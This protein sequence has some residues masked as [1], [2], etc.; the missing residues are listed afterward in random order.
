[1]QIDDIHYKG[2]SSCF[3]D[4]SPPSINISS[5][6]DGENKEYVEKSKNFVSYS[7]VGNGTF[8][9]NAPKLRKA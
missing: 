9:Q 1:M 8:A 2:C 7:S 6:Q 5:F 3:R 4:L